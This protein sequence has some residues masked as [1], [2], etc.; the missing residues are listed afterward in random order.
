MYT[1]SLSDP[2]ERSTTEGVVHVRGRFLYSGTA[3]LLV[4]GVTYG[5]FGPSG[6]GSEFGD[7]S[8][9]QKDFDSMRA[10]NV[11]SIRTYS[12]PPEWFLDLADAAALRVMVGIPWEQHVTFLDDS[13]RSAAIMEKVRT[14]VRA[15]AGHPAVLCYA[16]GNEIPASIVRWHGA[17]RVERFLREL[18]WLSKEEDSSALVTYVNYPS[19]EYLQLPFLDLVCFNVYLEC[20]ER[21]SSYL[22]RLLN[23]A[24][25]RPLIMGEIGLDSRRNG[26][27]MQAQL[28]E[29]QVRTAFD[30]GCAGTF[31]FSWTDEW[32]R[33]GCEIRD[34][35]FGVTR[36]NGTAKPALA[37]VA[38]AFSA[39]TVG[40][41]WP[42]VSVIVCTH[43]GERHIEETLS[44]LERV[45][46]PNYEVIV[47]DDG[48]ADRTGA[49]AGR[50]NVRLI[51]TDNHGLSAARITGL[52]AA[53]GEIVAYIDDDAYPDTEWLKRLAIVFLHSDYVGV[54]G[55]NLPPAG[56]SLV[57]QCVAHAPGGPIHVLLSDSDAE[58]IPGCNMAFRREHLLAVGGFDPQFRVAGDDVDVCWRV[59]EQGWKLGFSPTAMVYHHRRDSIRAYWKQQVGYGKAEALLERKWPAK[60]NAMG[61]PTWGGR[62]YNT[63]GLTPFWWRRGR[64]Y[65]GI[66]GTAPYQRLYHPA[67][68]LLSDLPLLP[69][70]YLVM[71]FL[72]TLS[73][74]GILWKPLLATIPLLAVAAGASILKAAIHASMACSCESAKPKADWK[75]LGIGLFLHLIHPLARLC[76]RLKYGLHPWRRRGTARPG[77]QRE[78]TVSVWTEDWQPTE[79]RLRLVQSAVR[80]GGTT[81]F[82]GGEYDTWDVEVQGGTLGGVRMRMAAEEHGM[83]R[84]MLR[85]RMWARCSPSGLLICVLMALLAFAAAYDRS[86]TAAGALGGVSLL[87][88]WRMFQECSLAMHKMTEALQLFQAQTGV[89]EESAGKAEW[90]ASARAGPAQ[91]LP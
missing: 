27:E 18:Y 24:G 77:F 76:G 44:A 48:S 2:R 21:L 34:W 31:V 78:R 13:G 63:R 68:T 35:D 71:A 70:W 14:A 47:V 45:D 73:L 66:W 6:S 69:E 8:R 10:A 62:V 11:N 50:F 19:T 41:A 75:A 4:R 64:I 79:D 84:Q 16:I 52:R 49:I 60:Y 22:A 25:E 36:R 38:R 58:H 37:A 61:H 90:S 74:I 30:A 89:E 80:A 42:R 7:R 54:G 72:A 3:K 46:Y 5:P 53:T 82:A 59:Q 29:H 88:G 12:V 56:D 17:R 9:V 57:A 33:G 23:V 55:P 83:G 87:V 32:H 39:H 67:V 85:F 26:E 28:L 65:Q 43:N 20:R 86:W 40:L 1:L 81:A 15:C 91:Q 51:Q